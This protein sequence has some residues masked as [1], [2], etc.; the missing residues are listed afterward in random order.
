MVE[1]SDQ[2]DGYSGLPVGPSMSSIGVASKRPSLPKNAFCNS[3][4][5]IN[6]IRAV[7]ILEDLTKTFSTLSSGP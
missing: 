4:P 7:P 1:I 2:F 5:I 3:E 6:E